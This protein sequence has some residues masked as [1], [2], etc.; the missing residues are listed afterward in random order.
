MSKPTAL[1]RNN[2]VALHETE[3]IGWLTIQRIFNAAAMEDA[4]AR[5][6][7]DWRD[8]GLTPKQIAAL[9]KN[10]QPDVADS[11]MTRYERSGIKVLTILDR[12]YPR[13][14]RQIARAPWVIY[15]VGRLELAARPSVGIVGTR[16]ATSYGR[17]V[18][19]DL[20]AACSAQGLTIVSGLARGIDT[21]A[22][23]GALNKAGGTVAVLATP[24]NIC[25]PAE[26]KHL[27]REIGEKGL[28]I[29]ETPPGTSLHPGLFPLRNR[30]IAGLS[31]GVV[32]VEA[33]EG[34]GALITAEDATK[35]NRDIFVV[36]GPITSPRSRGGMLL[37]RQGAK[38]VLDEEDILEEYRKHLTKSNDIQ[39]DPK[40]IL[41]AGDPLL[42]LTPD[43]TSIYNI[44]LDQ[45]RSIEELAAESGMTFGLL[46]S[47][48]LSLLIKRR[49]HQQ[50][51]SV[52]N[53][54]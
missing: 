42:H 19:E 17:R 44:L 38:P 14:L 20:S 43:E 22:H 15:Y 2:L 5:R 50:P 29:S 24:V 37:L 35:A 4:Q 7:A 34:S 52:Y 8:L 10:L 30:I 1:I 40:N 18:A 32:V 23:V 41:H 49:I 21:A 6:E 36:P 33:A 12:K 47:V 45:P 54:L 26:N 46:H 48:L 39:F 9:M 3:G 51:G 11:R 13:R 25:Y 16:L 28:L 31:L 53:V 27:Y